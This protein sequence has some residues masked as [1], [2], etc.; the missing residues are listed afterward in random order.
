M[1]RSSEDTDETQPQNLTSEEIMIQ[2]SQSDDSSGLFNMLSR[3]NAR[4]NKRRYRDR[5]GSSSSSSEEG[6]DSPYVFGKL[7]II[8]SST[9]HW[10]IACLDLVGVIYSDDYFPS[11]LGVLDLIFE[12]TGNFGP[13]TEKDKEHVNNV[14][15][16]MSFS[17]SAKE[18][19]QLTTDKRESVLIPVSKQIEKDL[20]NLHLQL[21]LR[22]KLDIA[23]PINFINAVQVMIAY[24]DAHCFDRKGY[25][26]S[27]GGVPED[28]FVDMVKE[29]S[30][31]CKLLPLPGSAFVGNTEICFDKRVQVTAK[32]DIILVPGAYSVDILSKTVTGK[33]RQPHVVSVVEVKNLEY[34]INKNYVGMEHEKRRHSNSSSEA[35]ENELSI[36][37]GKPILQWFNP[38]I[39]AKHGGDLLLLDQFFTEQ[40]EGTD[41]LREYL[42]GIIVVGTEVT[43]TVLEIKTGHLTDV[44]NK[45]CEGG[46]ATIF[47]SKPRDFLLKEDRDIL[48]E[49]F[50]RLNNGWVD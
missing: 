33:R 13:L 7:K 29:F 22:H 20:D 27:V 38:D 24:Q 28:M 12:K 16:S 2:T 17:M 41:G 39:L 15:D 4:K 11:P 46:K 30:K 25:R 40:L 47:Y 34:S 48:V 32:S 49:A 5:R 21:E 44:K 19:L 37:A 1:E 31:L 6:Y 18:L 35:S 3:Y 43:F 50:T 23:D 45:L 42:P 10:N 26:K 9:C 14:Q 36:H 8:P